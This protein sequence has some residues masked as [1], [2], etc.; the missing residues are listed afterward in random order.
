[1]TEVS[2]PS[3]M[4]TAVE[5]TTGQATLVVGIGS[6]REPDQVGWL[7]AD[8]VADL[9]LSHVTVR[10]AL[11]PLDL[12]DWIDEYPVV[13]VVDAMHSGLG[14]GAV[15]RWQWPAC[16]DI[17]EYHQT[18][19]GFDLISVLRLAQALGRIKSSITIWGIE[20]LS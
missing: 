9:N 10:R 7:I 14:E 5:T 4:L 18:T 17:R 3:A 16:D 20:V 11:V 6:H 8:L 12:L 1:M 2:V 13:H 19:H 15:R